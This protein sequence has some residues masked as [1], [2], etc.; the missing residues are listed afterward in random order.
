MS[1]EGKQYAED[2]AFVEAMLRRGPLSNYEAHWCLAPS[3]KSGVAV[4]VK[5]GLKKP[6][7]VSRTL[8]IDGSTETPD[9][10][11]TN[12]GRVLALEYERFIFLNTYVPHNGSNEERWAKRRK[13]D[14]KLEKYLKHHEDKKPVVWCGDLN[15]AHRDIDVGPDPNAFLMVGGFTI[16]E[17]TRFARILEHTGMTDVYRA[18]H[19]DRQTFTW[20]SVSGGSYGGYDR[21]AGMRLDY[22]VVPRTFMHRVKSVRV[23]TDRF[24]EQ[25]ARS[26]PISCFFGSDHCSLFLD[27]HE[28]SSEGDA[29]DERV[30]KQRKTAASAMENSTPPEVITIE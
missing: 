25:T 15:V 4:L 12:E 6:I 26:M 7:R 5:K 23:A 21:W 9:D 14:A 17:R 10:I 28:L 22:F 3:K 8:A 27:L 18:V 19:G 11:D 29:E 1:D 24:D 30:Q 13:W 20:R 16:P 2:K